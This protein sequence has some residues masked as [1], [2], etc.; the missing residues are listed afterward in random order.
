MSEPQSL[1]LASDTENRDE[2]SRGEDV[3]R[4]SPFVWLNLVCLDAPIVAITWQWCFARSFHVSLGPA[5]RAALF[6]T[7]WLIYLADRLADTWT[8]RGNSPRSLR[9]EF[10]RQHQP[11]WI[12][13]ILG[14]GLIDLW[15]VSRQ[16]DPPTIHAGILIGIISLLYL[17]VNFW[18]G[19]VWR[20][21]PIKEICIGSLFAFGTIVAFFSKFDLSAKFIAAFFL[22][23]S[24]CSLNCI[25][26]AVWEKTLDLVQKKNSIA[27][28]WDGV[29]SL[30][31]LVALALVVCAIAAAFVTQ[32]PVQLYV[33]IATS[34]VL[35]GVLDWLG[36]SIPRDERTALADLVLLTPLLLLALGI[37]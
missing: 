10:C 11:V 5:S 12:A 7:A 22:F 9:Q 16:L 30:L 27:T 34:A 8:L 36:E 15:V 1:L 33:C 14:I 21:L 4:I 17:A 18:L 37:A 3:A 13:A 29:Q 19:N 35:L 32:A 6:L 25:S 20:F 26:I 2:P 24:L 23:A 28:R 31:G